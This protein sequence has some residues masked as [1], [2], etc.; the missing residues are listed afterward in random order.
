VARS[1]R[2]PLRSRYPTQ[3]S[4]TASENK[5]AACF[6]GRFVCIHLVNLLIYKEKYWWPGAES[7][8][9]HKDFQSKTRP[10]VVRRNVTVFWWLG[11]GCRTCCR[12]L[13]VRRGASPY[14]FLIEINEIAI[15]TPNIGRPLVWRELWM[16][17]VGCSTGL[18][19]PPYGTGM[20][21]ERSCPRRDNSR[22]IGC[23][24]LR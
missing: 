2:T 21:R 4:E 17:S 18:L 8:H 24:R 3:V 14:V 19:A 15:P 7:N 6:T 9:R 11:S 5:K 23:D 16:A 10:S 1:H 22:S 12:T 13:L 20:L